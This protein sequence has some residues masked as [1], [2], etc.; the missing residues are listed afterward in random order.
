[1]LEWISVVISEVLR[2]LPIRIPFHASIGIQ[3][4]N[5]NPCSIKIP[6]ASGT[7]LEHKK[8]T[9]TLVLVVYKITNA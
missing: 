8:T 7:Y 9:Y 6:K 1:M 3:I 4:R 5:L 2:Y